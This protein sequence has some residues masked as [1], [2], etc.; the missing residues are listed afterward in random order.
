MWPQKWNGLTLEEVKADGKVLNAVK[1][2]RNRIRK[3]ALIQEGEITPKA[4]AA[5]EAIYNHF[6]PEGKMGKKECAKYVAGVTNTS[7][8]IQDSR[9]IDFFR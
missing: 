9:V 2:F 4:R 1:S 5:F 7:C 3:E 8:E 6:C